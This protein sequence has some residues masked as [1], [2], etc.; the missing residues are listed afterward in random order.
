VVYAGAGVSESQRLKPVARAAIPE[1]LRKAEQY[2]LLNDPEQAES[3]CLDVLAADPDDQRAIV[4][5]LLAIT[6]QFKDTTARTRVQHARALVARLGDPYQQAY[7]A[8]LVAERQAR[9]YLAGA[10]TAS[11]AHEG[12]VEAM[13]HYERAE[14]MRPPDNDDAILRWNSCQRTIEREKL[15]PREDSGEHPLE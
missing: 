3:I 5:L 14:T 2:R 6:D 15:R 9:A 4:C 10:M 1:A 13:A 11:F 8:G 12:L 7:Y